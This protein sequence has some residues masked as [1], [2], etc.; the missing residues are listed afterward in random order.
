MP[1]AS[2]IVPLLSRSRNPR[3]S[4]HAEWRSRAIVDC[5]QEGILV[6]DICAPDAPIV[7]V[8]R[9]FEAITGYSCDEAVGKN[10]RYLQGS[11][12]LQ[13]EIGVMRHALKAGVA[14]QV[15]LRNYRKDGSLFWN[16]LHL[17]PLGE[18]SSPTHYVGFIRDV[19]E[20]IETTARLREML[21]K[22]Q[23][24]GCLNRDGLL[25]RLEPLRPHRLLLIKVDVAHFHD[26]N[27]GYGY[28]LGDA[29]LCEI[30]RRLAVLD[31][32]AVARVGNDQFAV[33]FALREEAEPTKYLAR[34]AER[35][36]ARFDLPGAALTV[37]FATGYAVGDPGD[38][39]VMLVRQ[40]GAAMAQSNASQLRTP[41]AFSLSAE[42]QAF[43]RIRLTAEIQQGISAD[44]FT[45]H[46]QPKIDLQT[47]D[48]VGAEALLRWRHGLFG[49]QAPDTFI[50]LAEDTGLI[51]DIGARGFRKI[52]HFA[53]RVNR[54][55]SRPL[56]FAINVSAIEFTHRDMVAFISEVLE[57]TGADPSWLTLELTERLIATD[58]H[59]MLTIFHRVREL[60]VGLSIDD[61]GTEYSS[62]R[63][64]ERFPVT[65]VKIDRSFISNLQHHSLKRIIVGAVIE[66][67][68]E[69]GIDIVAEGIE[70]EGE[71]AML[72][73]MN[74]K[75]GQ[76]HLFSP[77]LSEEH[78]AVLAR[79]GILPLKGRN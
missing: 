78:F 22:D 50:R 23:L 48:F 72:R 58:S 70:Q 60:G 69:L 15:R 77:P 21:N 11:D 10:C 37:R 59:D 43:N 1:F 41:C 55:R 46:Y 65:E 6:A 57:E 31:A 44:E 28:D 13:P 7:Y 39:P 71:R 61:F 8:N 36:A 5:A 2:L 27:S 53:A 18:A 45:Y 63:Y 68:A 66:L 17:V 51:L 26:I 33:V 16:E 49:L 52:A 40:A 34:I 35:L 74:C 30:G 4:A 56:R 9:A 42:Q 3:R 79:D 25:A 32:E 47:G 20:Q 67:G 14:T 19:T 24:T 75:L 38:D 29:L 64:L 73:S 62:L 12:H 76:G 54:S